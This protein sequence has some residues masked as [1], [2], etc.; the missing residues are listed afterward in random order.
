MAKILVVDDEP[1]ICEVVGAFLGAE[2]ACAQT[3]AEG[4]ALIRDGRF[5]LAVI[6]TQ[7]RDCSGLDLAALAAN[8][9]LPVL[10]TSERPDI[11][12]ELEQ[13]AIPFL[14][15]PFDRAEL[16]SKANA[17]LGATAENIRRVKE[18]VARLHATGDALRDVL[19]HAN[20]LL[21]VSRA[22]TR[23]ADQPP[24]AGARVVLVHDEPEFGMQLTAALTLAGHLVAAF[25]D[26]MLA[27]DMLDVD[28]RVRMLITR[29][30]FSPGK[31]NG[32]SL[33]RMARTK[34]PGIRVLLIARP[35]FAEHAEGVGAFMATPLGIR[36]VVET[37]GRLL[38]SDNEALSGGVA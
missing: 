13:A 11:W 36:D 37:V 2:V 16:A 14:A 10:L 33:A 21:D 15:K 34:R 19:A 1:L 6:D 31:P 35:E 8:E 23:R 30:Q 20:R 38:R 9:N 24:A 7:L 32:V 12:R 26:P 4:A 17:I 22:I 5:D 3:A 18:S 27:L 28:P 29:A 25:T